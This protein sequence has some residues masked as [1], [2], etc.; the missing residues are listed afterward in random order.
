ML[1]SPICSVLFLTYIA[2]LL[3]SPAT[4]FWMGPKPH[5]ASMPYCFQYPLDMDKKAVQRNLIAQKNPVIFF[6]AA[7]SEVIHY[8]PGEL[9]RRNLLSSHYRY[10]S[11]GLVG[12]REK[13]VC[14]SSM[15]EKL[16]SRSKEIPLFFLP[17]SQN[18]F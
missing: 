5:L 14:A 2:V 18:A 9:E 4:L 7:T 12:V 3:N 8:E 11:M 10:V 13:I 6:S 15:F 1:H 16:F 17:L